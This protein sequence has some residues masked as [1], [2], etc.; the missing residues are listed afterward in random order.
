MKSESSEKKMS[1]NKVRMMLCFG[2]FAFV[3]WILSL[4]AFEEWQSSKHP[5]TIFVES[6]EP[7][8]QVDYEATKRM[9]EECLTSLT[10]EECAPLY[11][12]T[13]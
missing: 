2:M 13:K 9:Y 4:S 3:C 5:T 10:K 8:H 1:N 7:R 12:E 6:R 11:N